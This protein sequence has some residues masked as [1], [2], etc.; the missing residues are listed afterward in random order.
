[1]DGGVF[2][3]GAL[4]DALALNDPMDGDKPKWDPEFLERIDGVIL[5]AGD[6]QKTTGEKVH[7]VTNI[8]GHGSNRSSIHIVRSIDGKVRPGDQAGHEQ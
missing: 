3:N 1:M 4:E 6:S 7:E 2:K 5:V 8:F